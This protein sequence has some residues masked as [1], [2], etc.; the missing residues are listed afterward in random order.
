MK[1]NTILAAVAVMAISATT[2][3]A[4]LVWNGWNY[5]APNS[6]ATFDGFAGSANDSNGF[7]DSTSTETEGDTFSYAAAP[8]EAGAEASLIQMTAQGNLEGDGD[9]N[10]QDVL[11]GQTETTAS[12]GWFGEQANTST[13]GENN[14][15]VTAIGDNG[16]FA[17]SYSGL[18][19]EQ[20][21]SSFD[22][23]FVQGSNA[24]AFVMG[25]TNVT[26]VASGDTQS[27][28]SVS[29]STQTAAEAND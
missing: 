5:E 23:G 9:V 14:T 24:S 12:T 19:S 2:A 3:S 28:V 29:G 22:A 11:L 26:G 1:I 16:Q 18:Y 21:S 15:S 10:T 27:V 17:T 8:N 7:F 4:E 6:S 13:A 20:Q 25:A